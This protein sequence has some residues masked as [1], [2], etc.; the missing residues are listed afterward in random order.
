MKFFKFI[1][2][3]AFLLQLIIAA[4]VTVVL[5]FG[6]LK[7][8]DIKTDHNETV[9][10]PDLSKFELDIVDKKLEEM[11]LRREVLDSANYNPNY[12]PYSVLDQVPKPGKQVK[13]NRKIY[14]TL[15]PSGYIDVEIPKDLTRK[16]RRQ[17]EPTLIA[18]GFQ[19]G[20]IIM[21]PDIAKGAVLGL[22]HKGETIE[23]GDKL[24][25]TS[26]I[27]LVVGDGSL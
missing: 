13:E 17:V 12:P 27:D 8:L 4:V 10:V 25:K 23:A 24:P 16:T 26:T 2:S 9:E 22:R 6:A 18:L 1:F 14:L 11:N 5:V 15:N 19:I 20:D 21:K 7:Y 3:K